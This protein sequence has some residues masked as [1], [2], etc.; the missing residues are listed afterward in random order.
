M[1]FKLRGSIYRFY[2]LGTP[3]EELYMHWGWTGSDGG[4]KQGT[5]VG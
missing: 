5:I 3:E 2:S 4:F 1:L